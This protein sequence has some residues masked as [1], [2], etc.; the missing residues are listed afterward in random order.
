MKKIQIQFNESDYKVYHNYCLKY[1]QVHDTARRQSI[2]AFLD[3]YEK[4][5]L[6]VEEQDIRPAR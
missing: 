2:H 3:L 6:I 5:L 4:N 1:Y